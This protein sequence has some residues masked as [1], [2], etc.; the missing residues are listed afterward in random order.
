MREKRKV[1]KL[2]DWTQIEDSEKSCLV[3][4]C[5][6]RESCEVVSLGKRYWLAL[7][8]PEGLHGADRAN[9]LA[10]RISARSET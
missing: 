4:R 8:S 9:V 7:E 10:G 2:K 3:I 5:E 1:I 6:I